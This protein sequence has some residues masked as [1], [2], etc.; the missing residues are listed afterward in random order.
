MLIAGLLLH[1]LVRHASHFDPDAE[2]PYNSPTLTRR[3]TRPE[4]H[5]V[6]VANFDGMLSRGYA[7]DK[8]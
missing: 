1:V 3:R 7:V 4:T 2:L 5:E 6:M 8:T